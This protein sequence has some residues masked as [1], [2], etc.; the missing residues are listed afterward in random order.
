VRIA[1]LD[2][3][4]DPDH[5]SVPKNVR[6]DLARNF[7][8]ADRPNDAIDQSEDTRIDP[9]TAATSIADRRKNPFDANVPPSRVERW[10]W[11]F[12]GTLYPAICCETLVRPPAIGVVLLKE[13]VKDIAPLRHTTAGLGKD[14]PLMA[15]SAVGYDILPGRTYHA[16]SLAAVLN[17]G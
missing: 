1:H 8:D 6:C 9:Q 11:A 7:V 12:P 5:K 13:P 4:Y 15:I 10:L 16:A 17:Q 14:C 2:T 3:G